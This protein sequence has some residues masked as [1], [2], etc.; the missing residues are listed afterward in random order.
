VLVCLRAILALPMKAA[1]PYGAWLASAGSQQNAT[2]L[3]P[4][5]T[6]FAG[7]LGK[8]ARI[9][10]KEVAMCTIITVI[11]REDSA[12]FHGNVAHVSVKGDGSPEQFA[13][14]IRLAREQAGASLPQAW[15]GR[16][17]Y[18]APAI[19]VLESA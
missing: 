11:V 16:S 7:F 12:D 13:A 6:V 10:R 15:V 9:P 17:P 1:K 18:T 3:R 14:A 4:F 2:I 5:P 8:I 19:Q